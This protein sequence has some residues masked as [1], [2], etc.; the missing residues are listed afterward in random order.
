MPLRCGYM[1]I[2]ST[3][4]WTRNTGNERLD[5]YFTA[6]AN[7]GVNSRRFSAQCRATAYRQVIATTRN[8]SN[9]G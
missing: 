8:G 1:I 5:A 7:R 3:S 4:T 6:R 9:V 2:V